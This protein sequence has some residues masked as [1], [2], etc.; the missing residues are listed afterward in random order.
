MTRV[1]AEAVG[2][3]EAAPRILENLCN[4]FQWDLG[5][6]WQVDADQEVLG[7][8]RVWW[9]SPELA[10]LAAAWLEHRLPPGAGLPGR[11]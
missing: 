4:A 10:P 3:D 9:G 11:V 8:L 6:V 2:F 7:C 1:L 5:G